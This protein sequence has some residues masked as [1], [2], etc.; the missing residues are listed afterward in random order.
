MGITKA[1]TDGWVTASTDP[2]LVAFFRA[3]SREEFLPSN[4]Y[5]SR[6]TH[7]VFRMLCKIVDGTYY[8]LNTD[9][10]L[11]MTHLRFAYSA[12]PTAKYTPDWVRLFFDGLDKVRKD[13]SVA[14]PEMVQSGLITL[15]AIAAGVETDDLQ[16]LEE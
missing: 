13:R 16:E 9:T 8:G 15:V 1:P 4:E 14:G 6:I 10:K 3:V 11:S 5:N 12:V 2:D 7:P